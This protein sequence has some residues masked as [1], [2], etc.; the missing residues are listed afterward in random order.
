[1]AVLSFLL[2]SLTWSLYWLGALAWFLLT[3]LWQALSLL[4]TILHQVI[5]RYSPHLI[6]HISKG[7]LR[8]VS[9]AVPSLVGSSG[10]LAYWTGRVVVVGTRILHDVAV[11]VVRF[12]YVLWG[13]D[14]WLSS[15]LLGGRGRDKQCAQ[16]EA[17][18]NELKDLFAEECGGGGSGGG[19]TNE[20]FHMLVAEGSVVEVLFV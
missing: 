3:V 20:R 5:F 6:Y 8:L 7:A 10:F 17:A 11:R 4:L 14:R 12:F 2:R 13:W 18:D 1:M 19:G 15:L 16:G 9:W